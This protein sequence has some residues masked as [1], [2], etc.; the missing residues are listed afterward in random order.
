MQYSKYWTPFDFHFSLD[1]FQRA[2]D[3]N[4]CI[5]CPIDFGFRVGSG[6]LNTDA[7]LSLW[8]HRIAKSDDINA[9]G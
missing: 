8:N 9:T 1:Y 6:D 2:T 4:E 5:N 3:F 7:C